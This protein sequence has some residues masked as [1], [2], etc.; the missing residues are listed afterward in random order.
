MSLR[1]VSISEG[2]IG[3]NS[4]EVRAFGLVGSGVAVVGGAQLGIAYKL[5]RPSDATAI[6]FTAAY[7]TANSVN[8]CRHISEFY[9]RAGEGV[10]LHVIL[11]DQAKKPEEMIDA[12]KLLA[13]E[14]EG[15]ISDFAFAYNPAAGYVAANV[16]GLDSNVK[17]AIPVLNDFG[18]WAD[19][20]DMPCHTILEGRGI[21]DTLSS[22]AD[23]RALTVGAVDLEACKVTLVVGQDWTYADGLWPMGQKFADVGTFL[24]VVASQPWNRNPGEQATQNLTNVTKGIWTVGGLSNHKKY[25]EVF[26]S[27]ETMDA[28]G[29][30]FPIRYTGASGYW[31]NDG[32][33]CAPIVID[34]DGKM[35][36]HEIYYS[37]TIDESKRALRAVY[38]PEVKTTVV[39]DDDGL[40]PASKVDYYDA[41]G[42]IEFDK[43]AGK[44][45]ISGGTTTT[46]AN[47]DLVVEKKLN[48]AFSVIPTGCV[49]E[50]VGTI[51]LSNS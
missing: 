36:Q 37:H 15:A 48:V 50:I 3:A 11:V 6:G 51:N 19:A 12:A 4:N 46:D 22:L 10:A 2:S 18:A 30:V 45:L 26:D 49:G 17:A 16:D 34:A 1:G 41:I 27:L 32:H 39:L 21:S 35:N 14:A 9:R 20:H 31:W 5:L 13:V 33:V 40:L 29:Y 25:S 7:D 28:K 43:M 47:S 8:I 44:Q 23:L 24:G 38:L 42:D